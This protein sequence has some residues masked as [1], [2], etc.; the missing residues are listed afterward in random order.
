MS[1]LWTFSSA[2][3]LARR[4]TSKSIHIPGY[5]KEKFSTIISPAFKCI[6]G[7][8]F[9]KHVCILINNNCILE[10]IAHVK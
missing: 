2:G 6:T 5:C 4:L 10:L 7:I 1:T 8:N 9:Q 3:D